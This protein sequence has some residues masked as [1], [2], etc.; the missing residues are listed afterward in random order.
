MLHWIYRLAVSCSG[1]CSRSIMVVEYRILIKNNIIPSR[2]CQLKCIFKMRCPNLPKAVSINRIP[3][4]PAELAPEFRHPS[5][6]RPGII[7]K[8]FKLNILCHF[9]RLPVSE[10]HLLV[11]AADNFA[12]ILQ[13]RPQ[14]KKQTCDGRQIKRRTAP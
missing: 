2:A 7:L 3:S 8:K 1:K 13:N 12:S 5:N 10:S 4:F 9:L 11:S 6:R 14:Q